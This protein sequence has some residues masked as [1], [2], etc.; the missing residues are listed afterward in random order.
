MRITNSLILLTLVITS[1]AHS[2][3]SVVLIRHAEKMTETADPPLTDSGHKRAGCMAEWIANQPN[4][5][6]IQR[7]YSS[8]YR[9]TLETAAAIAK[10][11]GVSI[12]LYDPRKLEQMKTELQGISANTVIVGHSNTTP[13]LAGLLVS[14]NIQKMEESDYNSFWQ[15]DA[16]S[17]V[18]LDQQLLGCDFGKLE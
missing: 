16:N 17:A 3:P 6:N 4:S 18:K 10:R 8:N 2:S 1:V 14:S 5:E 7:V 15:V 12:R 9:R 11:L 13:K